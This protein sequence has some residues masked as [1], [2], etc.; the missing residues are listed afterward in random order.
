MRS[1]LSTQRS[2]SSSSRFSRR[3]L[4]TADAPEPAWLATRRARRRAP[5][6]RRRRAGGGRG[7]TQ[8]CA[9]PGGARHFD[10]TSP[11]PSRHSPAVPLARNDSF[12]VQ[13]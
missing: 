3:L 9:R 13:K 10:N 12:F 5:M 11:H 2:P 6:R 1:E 4:S 7:C 8:R